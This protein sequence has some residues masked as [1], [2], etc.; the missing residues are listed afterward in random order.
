MTEWDFSCPDW[1]A[2]LAA[3]E[4]LV[5]RLPLD[6]SAAALAVDTFNNLRLP[7]IV[8]TPR[9]GEAAGDW[10]RDGLAAAFG[11]V[12]D[13]R[14]RVHE[15]FDLVPK[16]NSKTTYAAGLMMTAAI[17]NDPEKYPQWSAPNADL[18]LIGPTQQISERAFDQASG[19]V[20]ADREGYLQKRFH[21]QEHIKTIRD[22]LTGSRIRVRT[23]SAD[24]LT[25]VIPHVVLIDELHRLGTVAYAEK[26]IRQIRGGLAA[27]PGSR[28]LVFI[29]TQSD[30]RPAGVFKNE[31]AVARKIRDGEIRGAHVGMLP[32][33]YEFPEAMQRAKDKPWM[34]PKTWPMVM[35][36]LGLSIGL[37]ELI[38]DF[39]NE[40]EKG[41]EA[42]R[43]WASQHLNI[44]IGLALHGDRWAGA[45]YWEGAAEP[46]LTLDSLL[47]RSE[48]AV[49]G[50]D[51]GGRDD[52]L[53]IAVAG[54][55]KKTKRWLFW[56]HAFCFSSVLEERK[57]I[58][59]RLLDFE[60]EGSLTIFGR[61]G[62]AESIPI[63]A[64]PTSAAMSAGA[65]EGETDDED[66]PAEAPIINFDEDIAAAVE[67]VR[68]VM[69]SGLLPEKD[70]IGLDPE[71]VADFVDALAALDLSI[72]PGAQVRGVAQGYRLNSAIVGMG[73]KV[74]NGSLVHDGSELMKWCVG[75]AKAEQRGNALIITKQVSG[76]AKIDP[77]VAGFNAFALLA[78][79]PEA[80]GGT[81][82][83]DYE[84]Q[85][86]VA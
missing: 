38:D 2:R 23:F 40:K 76:K 61:D 83:E 41:D 5:P 74:A 56:F 65:D 33:L 22:R 85:V 29:T 19:M 10:F 78:W 7:D 75:N 82:P 46:G 69:E 86:I 50:I 8:G 3:G 43:L 42:I 6:E 66:A 77:L 63:F 67:I 9:L 28:L 13:G 21:V 80:A 17:L 49:V 39:E 16:K 25:G 4:S 35:P 26:V 72:G 18:L 44:E 73:R 53:G 12:V 34:D 27:K 81:L 48:V 68:I 60:R 71:C 11:S 47:E 51:G 62:A 30:S 36:N 14:R 57:E 20:R 24:V 45:D 52:L 32:L 70:A 1:E 54:R 37:Q 31:L 58:A 79:N 15:L 59:P 84:L 55:E 64:I